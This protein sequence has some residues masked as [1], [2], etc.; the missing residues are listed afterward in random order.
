MIWLCAVVYVSPLR[1]LW[2]LIF[3]VQSGDG[4]DKVFEYE[5][6]GQVNMVNNRLEFKLLGMNGA[7]IKVWIVSI[8]GIYQKSV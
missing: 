3:T 1:R 8:K 7:W 6:V 5:H 4:G 2:G